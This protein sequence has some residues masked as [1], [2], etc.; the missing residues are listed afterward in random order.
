MSL[1]RGVS[2]YSAAR[3]CTN[4]VLKTRNS[5][6]SAAIRTFT[7]RIDDTIK[8]RRSIVDLRSDTVT[9][10]TRAMLECALH[11]QTGDDV[12]SEDP[13]VFALEDYAAD[14]FGKDRA[15]FVP[16]GTMANL[17]AILAHCHGKLGSEV[18]LGASSHLSLYEGGNVATLGGIHT[19]Q[20]TES[21]DDATIST[22]DILDM[23]RTDDDDHYAATALLCLEN[24]HNSLGGIA[25]T[26][27]YMD[28]MGQLAQQ[29]NIP[30][31]VDGARIFNAAIATDTP[32]SDLVAHA[33][34]VSVCLSKSLGAPLGSLVVGSTETMT[35]AK[36][37][38]KH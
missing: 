21:V 19:R 17:V 10:P 24:T 13:T 30:M 14:L 22:R 7:T 8:T 11:A 12:Y 3:L 33:D 15:L 2:V 4:S 1:R 31:H 28:T 9:S 25:L 20:I 35:L 34:T 5:A 32:V 36:R 6:K 26:K 29:Q 38:R 16:T 27:Q 18:I 37:A 23:F